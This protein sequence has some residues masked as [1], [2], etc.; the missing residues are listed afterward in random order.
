MTF[1]FG[2]SC[3]DVN[4]VSR[5][6]GFG[7][8]HEVRHASDSGVVCPVFLVRKHLNLPIVTL[9]GLFVGMFMM[10]ILLTLAFFGQSRC[11]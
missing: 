7:G 6:E 11:S 2:F 9:K 1:V 3:F 4:L 8:H 10:V 5:V